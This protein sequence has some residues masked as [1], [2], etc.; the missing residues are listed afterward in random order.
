M[1]NGEVGR[2]RDFLL[3][4]VLPGVVG[5]DV[6]AIDPPEGA[7][8]G[9]SDVYRV[10]FESAERRVFAIS[11]PTYP[12]ISFAFGNRECADRGEGWIVSEPT[13]GGSLRASDQIFPS[14]RSAAVFAAERAGVVVSL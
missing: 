9:E 2:L 13:N 10:E 14:L 8:A 12:T 6:M 11:Q 5:V 7:P 1:A 3:S 4:I